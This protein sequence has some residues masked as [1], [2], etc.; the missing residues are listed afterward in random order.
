MTDLAILA[1]AIVAKLQ[2]IPGVVTELSGDAGRVFAYEDEYPTSLN[3]Q[4]AIYEMPDPAVMV[5]WNGTGPTGQR[6]EVWAHRFSLMLKAANKFTAL[7]AAISNGIPAGGD[8]LNFR[9][10]TIDTSCDP[11]G[12][13]NFDR[14]FLL[15]TEQ[16]T[17]DYFEAT[18]TLMERGISA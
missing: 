10:T 16:S 18:F 15:V 4:R 1:A 12:S 7:C 6:Y 17:L 5:V 11:I 9:R 2:A 3:L 13:M 14:R 8:G